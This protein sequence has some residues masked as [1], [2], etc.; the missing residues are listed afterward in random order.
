MV[1]DKLI[2]LRE[3]ENTFQVRARKHGDNY[4]NE[5]EE[6]INSGYIVSIE[7][8]PAPVEPVEPEEEVTP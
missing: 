5:L 8:A 7:E 2:T 3:G 1:Y 6:P 4:V